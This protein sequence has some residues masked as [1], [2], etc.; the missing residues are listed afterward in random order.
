MG[1]DMRPESDLESFTRLQHL[2]AIPFHDGLIQDR[3]R[4][5]HMFQFLAD[6]SFAKLRLGWKGKKRFRIKCH[7]GRMF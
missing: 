2:E 5:G 7:F 6:K 1:L 3:G 4:R